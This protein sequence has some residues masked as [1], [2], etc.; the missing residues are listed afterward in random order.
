MYK[1]EILES[2]LDLRPIADDIIRSQE[3][4]Q[5]LMFCGGF[6]FIYYSYL[7]RS[8]A[9]SLGRPPSA[10][11]CSSSRRRCSSRRTAASIEERFA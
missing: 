3:I 4:P 8:T 6:P 10:R 5:K 1:L 7:A 9:K 11:R 2:Q